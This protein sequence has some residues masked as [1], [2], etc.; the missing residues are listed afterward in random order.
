MINLSSRGKSKTALS[1]NMQLHVRRTLSLAYSLIVLLPLVLL[2]SPALIA[3]DQLHANDTQVDY[4]KVFKAKREMQLLY[5]GNVVRRY[6]ISLGDNPVGHKQQQGDERTPEGIY[7]IDYRNPKSSYHL[8]LH[9]NYPSKQDKRNAAKRG[10]NPGGDIFIHGLPNGMGALAA[11]FRQ[12]DWTD[13]CIAV[14]NAEIE[15]IWRFVKNGTRIEI[16][17]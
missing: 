7:T 15:E 16:L 12:R 5:K 4:V 1:V 2:T 14:N 6:A 13:G 10:V 17:P 9:I 3:A 11:A 8:S